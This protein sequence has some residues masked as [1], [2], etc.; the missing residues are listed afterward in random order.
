MRRG[1]DI[2]AQ[3]KLGNR[4]LCLWENITDPGML[5]KINIFHTNMPFVSN[6]PED[7]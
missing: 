1:G 2:Q 7:N 5:E 3:L 6:V 4:I